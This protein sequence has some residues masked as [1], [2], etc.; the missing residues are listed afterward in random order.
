MKQ[1]RFK[2]FMRKKMHLFNLDPRIDLHELWTE[3]MDEC[4]KGQSVPPRGGHVVDG[5]APIAIGA[6]PAPD[7]QRFCSPSLTHFGT[8]V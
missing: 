6:S 5:H 4:A 1:L 8:S 2:K 3:A 7:L